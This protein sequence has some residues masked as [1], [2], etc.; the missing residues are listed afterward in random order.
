MKAHGTWHMAHGT[1]SFIAQL[2]ERS[3]VNRE[4]RGS[5]PLEGDTQS[6]KFIIMYDYNK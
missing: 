6:I 5:T 4:V 1:R 3:A 2:V